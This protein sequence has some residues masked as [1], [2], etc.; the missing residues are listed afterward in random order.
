MGVRVVKP[1]TAGKVAINGHTAVSPSAAALRTHTVKAGETASIIARKYGL[2]LDALL[3][4]NPRI[5]P[6]RLRAG[7]TLSIPATSF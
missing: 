4:A 5:E 6:R 2:K 1:A 7:Q 3:V